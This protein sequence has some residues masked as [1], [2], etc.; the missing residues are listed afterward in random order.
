[1]LSSF[2]SEGRIITET[3]EVTSNNAKD[4]S[5]TQHVTEIFHRK[6]IENIFSA[7]WFIS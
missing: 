7:Y 5:S 1:M 6:I 3:I 2:L 4:F